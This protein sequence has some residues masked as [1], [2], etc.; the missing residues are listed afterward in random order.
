MRHK[1]VLAAVKTHDLDLYPSSV[2]RGIRAQG[3]VTWLV[4]R[5]FTL[6]NYE[7][8][9]PPASMKVPGQDQQNVLSVPPHDI[10]CNGSV[11]AGETL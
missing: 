2:C 9:V 11:A 5:G 8:A 10:G 6:K 7:L 1:V 4:T 3:G